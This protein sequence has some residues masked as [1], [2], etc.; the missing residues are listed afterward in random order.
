VTRK[1]NKI[2]P[3]FGKSI[4]NTKSASVFNLKAQN[5]YIKIL[6]KPSNKPW[7][8][9]ARLWENRLSKKVASTTKFRPSGHTDL[10]LARVE[11]L[12]DAP[13]SGRLWT[14]PQQGIQK[15]EVSLYN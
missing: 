3:N 8:E 7:L 15:G 1:L 14:Y 10:E 4:Q 9:T 5:I 13:L 2:L 6:L 12:L 11:Q